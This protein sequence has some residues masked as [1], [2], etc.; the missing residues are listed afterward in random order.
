MPQVKVW[1]IR[2]P[3]SMRLRPCGGREKRGSRF[4]RVGAGF[5]PGLKWGQVFNLPMQRGRAGVPQV[6]NLRPLENL[7]P[8]Q[9][10]AASRMLRTIAGSVAMPSTPLTMNWMPM[11]SSRNPIT[12]VRAFMPG[13]PIKATIEPESRRVA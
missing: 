3:V 5:E 13:R 7:R 8:R 2:A 11:H 10:A 1:A 12:L 6:A 4:S 9:G